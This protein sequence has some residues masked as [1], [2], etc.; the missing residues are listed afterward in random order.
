MINMGKFI[1]S[2]L[3]TFDNWNLVK[4]QVSLLVMFMLPEDRRRQQYCSDTGPWKTCA[5]GVFNIIWIYMTF[6]SDIGLAEK[7]I[8]V[9]DIH[10][11]IGTPNENRPLFIVKPKFHRGPYMDQ[12]L[13]R[14]CLCNE[15]LPNSICGRRGLSPLALGQRT[16]ASRH[17]LPRTR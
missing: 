1:R 5:S 16:P 8:Y 3:C 4:K 11:G 2:H 13:Y 9:E 15:L 17:G 12:L 14:G 10:F 7:L 6:D